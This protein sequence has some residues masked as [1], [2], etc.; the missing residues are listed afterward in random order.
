MVFEMKMLSLGIFQ[1]FGYFV[2]GCTGFGGTAIASPINAMV[3]GPAVSVPYGTMI[4]LVPLYYGAIRGRHEISWKDLGR[5]L[6]VILPFILFGNY[7]GA[8]MSPAV[9]KLGI[10]AAVTVIAIM[11][12]WKSII[13]PLVLHKE[14]VDP[15]SIPDTTLR[16]VGRW[17][18]L[19]VGG[20]VHGAFN[21]GGPLMTV[22]ILSAVKDKIHFRNT[23]F[24][25]WV[26][27]NTINAIRQISTGLWTPY[28]ITAGLTAL[29]FTLIAYYFGRRFTN[30]I[31]KEQFL[32]FVY[33][34][35][36]ISGG[37]MF[38]NSLKAFL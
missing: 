8:I 1:L 9:A 20:A 31:N 21:C 3:L 12:I 30:K 28:A 37:S 22:Y 2:E 19:V 5:L 24:A 13:N 25:M 33:C 29:P 34:V 7:L 17:T 36:L 18:A 4:S 15:D 11:N 32:R 38:I 10:G 23:M 16:K 35:L 27:T 26:V 6:V 14:A